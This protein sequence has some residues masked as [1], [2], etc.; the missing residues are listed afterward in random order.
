MIRRISFLL[1]LVMA[2]KGYSWNALGHRLVAQI[3]YNHLTPKAKKV[4]NH[5]NHA[6]DS[7]YRSQSFVNAAAWLDGLRYQNDLWLGPKH[8]IDI[9]FSWDGTELVQPDDINAVSAIIDASKIL[10]ENL[11]NDFTKG[12]TLRIL[13]HVVGDIHQPLH[14]ANQFSI[15]HPQGDQGGNLFPLSSNSIATNLHSYWDKGG[16]LLNNAE[17]YSAKQLRLKAHNIEKHWPCH[18]EDM[19]LDP[20]T[21]ATESHQIAITKVYH[22]KPGQKPSQKYQKM[23]EIITEQRIALAGCRLA[24]LLNKL[25]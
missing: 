24:A 13:L 18:L 17:H 2:V 7:M 9:P 12:F 20:E 22:L 6:L 5:Y 15:E 11:A 21:W 8:Y 19:N 3:A 4:C 23:T 25:V 10:Q 14:A 1:F 16:G